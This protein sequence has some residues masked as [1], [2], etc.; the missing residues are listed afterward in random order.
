[1]NY[2]FILKQL[3]LL[4]AVVSPTVLAATIVSGVELWFGWKDERPA[5]IA[6]CI[7]VL[8]SASI[9]GACWLCARKSTGYL[10]RREA[11]F[12]VA[13]SW[14]LGAVLS[15]MPYYLW[16]LIAEDSEHVF[17][18]PIACYFEA[19]SGLT[20]TGA[21]VLSDIEALPRSILLWRAFTHWLGGLGI[22]VLFVA[23]L[24][25]LGVGGRKLFRVEAPGP[26]P[27]G[28]H[29]HIR[30]TARVLWYIYAGL[31]IAQVLALVLAGMGLF[32]AVCHAFATLATGG[33]S[34]KNASAGAYPSD[35]I[36]VIL[37]VFMV[38]AGV[39]FGLYHQLIR[40]R[41]REVVRDPELRMYLLLLGACSALIALWLYARPMTMTDGQQIQSAGAWEAARTATFTTVSIQT[42]TG[43]C[44]ADFDLWALPI[45]LILVLLMFVGGCAGSTSGGIKVIRIWIAFKVMLRE[46]ERVFRPYVVRPVRLSGQTIDP[47][48]KLATLAYVLGIV[49]LFIAGA[50]AILLI[51]E[52][53]D[54][55]TAATASVASLCTI[56][57]GLAQVGATQNYGW[58]SG[59]SLT[60]L[61]VLMLIGR[62]EI[63]AILV[64][65]S[66]SFW[67][68][69]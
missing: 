30:E 66:P 20:T 47:E 49:V 50:G 51:E 31:T 1:V 56:G 28:V 32:D 14:V 55:A 8:V 37:I 25:S 68:S 3:A 4:Q 22:V 63:F 54:F 29:P 53:V 11:L 67:R 33:F 2:R 40:R 10:D 38:L 60:V 65:L 7:T 15:G 39:N 19:M 6:L 17:R 35:V 48:L 52:G 42:T 9:G 45:Q 61:T 27:G 57:P 36:R 21:T 23:V 44:D 12:L 59:G 24:P 62:L 58:M 64:L 26:T 43:F 34:T 18:S 41:W 69:H 5:L 16:S 46:I 13:V